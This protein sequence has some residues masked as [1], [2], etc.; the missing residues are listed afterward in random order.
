MRGQLVALQH[1]INLLGGNLQGRLSMVQGAVL[2]QLQSQLAEKDAALA[3]SEQILAGL[4]SEVERLSCR[5][6]SKLAAEQS[7]RERL[8]A[9]ASQARLLCQA[10][11][12]QLTELQQQLQQLQQTAANQE[13]TAS[14]RA[15][16]EQQQA[17]Q[18][19]QKVQQLEQEL[20]A[21]QQAAV[22]AGQQVSAVEGGKNGLQ[23][24]VDELQSALAEKH[25]QIEWLE[26]KIADLENS[27]MASQVGGA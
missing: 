1:N 14:A 25:L 23:Q 10:R 26:G 6:T 22:Y 8:S 3:G 4:Q 11:G 27:D 21:A 18:L 9:E 15:G 16:L 20:C 12:R 7:E 19:H 24:Q 13:Q 2:T 5:F 17:E